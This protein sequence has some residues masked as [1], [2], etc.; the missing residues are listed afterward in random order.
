MNRRKLVF[1]SLAVIIGFGIMVMMRGALNKAPK[2]ASASTIE[3]L[4][5]ATDVPAGQFLQAQQARWQPWEK[6]NITPALI[7]KNTPSAAPAGSG[8]KPGL[9]V[10]DNSND[11]TGA[12][13]RT[14]IRAGE[15][16]LKGQIVKPQERGFLSAVLDPGKRAVAAPITNVTGIAGFVFPGD[17]VDL[18]LTHMIRSDEGGRV[19]QRRASA[20]IVKNVRVLALDQNTSDQQAPGQQPKPAKVVTLEVDPKQ[21]EVVTLSLQ[22][23]TLSLSLCSLT[24]EVDGKQ[25]AHPIGYEEGRSP[26]TLDSDISNLIPPPQEKKYIANQVVEILR[27]KDRA[28]ENFSDKKDD[29][30]GDKV[31]E[32][33]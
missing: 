18:I 16:I 24:D 19:G 10:N 30:E 5:A 12:V 29:N 3:I 32:G 20:T 17:R 13:V 2:Q 9:A 33:Q 7:V 23:G 28:S 31:E 14:G 26:Y 27:G 6:Q 8:G 21:A 22:L 1:L 4:V 11:Y 15:P 25:A